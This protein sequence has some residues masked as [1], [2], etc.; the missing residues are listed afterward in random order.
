MIS[1]HNIVSPT[2]QSPATRSF[3]PSSIHQRS[4]VAWRES[5]LARVLSLEC[6]VT[7]DKW[8]QL[9]C[10]A[11]ITL[12]FCTLQAASSVLSTVLDHSK[13]SGFPLLFHPRSPLDCSVQTR[14][15]QMDS[16]CRSRHTSAKA[17]SSDHVSANETE[18]SVGGVGLAMLLLPRPWQGTAG[19]VGH[20]ATAGRWWGGIGDFPSHSFSRG[21]PGPTLL[22]G[23]IPSTSGMRPF[24]PMTATPCTGASKT[25]RHALE[26]LVRI[27]KIHPRESPVACDSLF[28]LI[29]PF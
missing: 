11:I 7:I 12:G 23:R 14:R 18:E 16:N 9:H 2:C 4:C 1:S 5:T 28:V 3:H 15:A 20:G 13:L 17:A 27:W 26:R 24:S 6:G 21:G 29:L 8:M 25:A 19:L 10:A 22:V